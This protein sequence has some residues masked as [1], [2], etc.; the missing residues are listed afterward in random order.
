MDS[1]KSIFTTGEFADLC[2]VK[3]QTLFHYDEIGLL[4]PEYRSENG[5]RSYSVHQVEIFIVIDMLKEIGMSLTEIKNF[6]QFKS[7]K[8]S[9]ELLTEKEKI[10]K[11]KIK[12]MQH[13]QKLIQNKK[14][15]I[16]EALQLNFD[17]FTIEEMD[18]EW[19]VLSENILNLPDKDA[20]KVS[21]LFLKYM[22]QEGLFIDNAGAL[23]RQEQ[24]EAGDY[25]NYSNLYFRTHQ[26]DL[27]EKISKK[28][29]KYAVGYH[30][31]SYLTIHETY[32]KIKDYLTKEGYRVCGHS[33][34]EFLYVME[35]ASLSVEDNYVT[36]IMIKVE[37]N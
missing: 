10:V 30:K 36:K 17:R 25:L 20:T 6:L 26:L 5:Y 24:V 33:F 31:G 4:K 27:A 8:S 37:E 11:M 22:K 12:K 32:E 15:Q 7:L 14:K 3:K 21:M 34:E 16:K 1:K 28:S 18:T 35:G 9:I 2:G 13:T 29:G 23:I 19:Y